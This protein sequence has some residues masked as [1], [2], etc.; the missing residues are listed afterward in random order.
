MNIMKTQLNR[1]I[2]K[3]LLLLSL[4]IYPTICAAQTGNF[5]NDISSILSDNSNTS[6]L[7]QIIVLISIMS[8]APT[9][10]IMV[11][12]YVRIVVVFSF[13][14]SSLGL[15]QTPPN[16]VLLSLAMFLTFFV[17]SPT[18]EQAYKSGLHPWLEERMDEQEAIPKIASPFKKFMTANTRD[19]DINLFIGIAN[20]DNKISL[21][22][23]PFHVITP[24]FMISELRR[25][26]EIGF[27]IALPFLII[28]IL[29]ASLLMA[30]G[31]MMMPPVMIALP[32]KVIFFVVIDGWYLLAGSLVK[33]FVM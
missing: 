26:F 24:A 29:V 5:A 9:I 17:M 3:F 15:Q 31:M 27:L 18:I 13:L 16:Q 8:A 12:S 22:D 2:Y 28:D 33:S 10:L 1:K 32:F 7:L 4:I 19:K 23:I 6:R 14:R 25:A 21:E 20:I 11:T 30:M